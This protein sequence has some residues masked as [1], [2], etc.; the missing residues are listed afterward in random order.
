MTRE[1]RII[2]ELERMIAKAMI[3]GLIMGAVGATIVWWLL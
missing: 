1:Q 2:I 3:E